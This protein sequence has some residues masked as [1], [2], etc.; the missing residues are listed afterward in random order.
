MIKPKKSLGQNFLRD[1]N[2]IRKIID[3]V[4]PQEGEIILEI[5]PGTGAITEGLINSGALLIAVEIDNRAAELLANK[6]PTEHFPN[7]RLMNA[8][9]L[10]TNL[11]TLLNE[12]N[13]NGRIKVV[14]NI[15]YNISG[16]LLFWMVDNHNH[17]KKAMLMVQKEVARRVSTTKPGTKDYGL[18][19]VVMALFADTRVLFDISPNCFYPVPKVTSSFMSIDFRE[20]DSLA[21]DTFSK[22]IKLAKSAFNQRRKMLR[23]SL[24]AYLEK[25]YPETSIEMLTEYFEEKGF[26]NIF[27]KRSDEIYVQDYLTINEFIES[28]RNRG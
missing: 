3:A 20:I 9:I 25:Y 4:D 10:D 11:D 8:D 26:S 27:T 14:G 5:G 21:S 23:N 16:Q 1:N 28:Y 6:F 13:L 15:P 22:V 24:A 19:S 12:Q 17:I 7:F 18:T 2:I